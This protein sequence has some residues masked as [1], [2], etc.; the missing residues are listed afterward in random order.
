MAY[1]FAVSC[2]DYPCMAICRGCPH[3]DEV[4]N[5]WNEIKIYFKSSVQDPA[6]VM[7][8]ICSLK[9]T[10]N[11]KADYESNIMGDIMSLV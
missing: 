1:L 4:K 10:D 8:T 7:S 2:L 5:P 6:N 11:P 9:G 3:F